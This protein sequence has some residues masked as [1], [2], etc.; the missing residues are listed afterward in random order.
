MRLTV[1]CRE[2]MKHLSTEASKL[3]K[4][5]KKLQAVEVWTRRRNVSVR[6]RRRIRS[7]YAEIW[8]RHDGA[9]AAAR[10][11]AAPGLRRSCAH[12]CRS[13]AKPS[14]TVNGT[15]CGCHEHFHFLSAWSRRAA[16]RCLLCGA[17]GRAAHG[18]RARAGA[19]AAGAERCVQLHDEERAARARRAPHAA[20]RAGGA[21]R[22]AGGRSRNNAVAAAGR[23]V[24][25]AAYTSSAC[26]YQPPASG[27]HRTPVLPFVSHVHSC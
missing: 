18:H 27:C 17:A 12:C 15:S 16:G 2:L 5:R 8:V 20:G 1:P 23:R 7:Y 9:P 6:L 11:A 22:R 13:F 14:V 3:G 25:C 26:D 19:A 21:Q 10:R 4:L 24:S